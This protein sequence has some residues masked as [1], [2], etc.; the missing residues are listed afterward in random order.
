MG[1]T[2]YYY[3]KKVSRSIISVKVTKKSNSNHP[4]Q[5]F[6][7][8]FLSSKIVYIC[9]QTLPNDFPPYLSQVEKRGVEHKF[10]SWRTSTSTTELKK[11]LVKY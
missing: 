3:G 2:N 6:V 4:Y 10:L 8:T 7:L 11:L 1:L 9:L 5:I